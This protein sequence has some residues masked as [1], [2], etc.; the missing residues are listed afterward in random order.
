M[1]RPEGEDP[2]AWLHYGNRRVDTADT[3]GAL[4]A[5]RKARA[6]AREL[7]DG[8]C[9]LAALSNAGAQLCGAGRTREARPILEEAVALAEQIGGQERE[10]RR[11]LR[12]LSW[13][14]EL[15]D[16][17]EA[18]DRANAR[19]RASY[20][21]DLQSARDRAVDVGHEAV[22]AHVRGEVE[23]AEEL[24]LVSIDLSRASSTRRNLGHMLENLGNLRSSNGRMSG[25]KELYLEALRIHRQEKNVVGI[26][27][28][29]GLLANVLF[30][31]EDYSGAAQLMR[32]AADL[33]GQLGNQ[34]SEGLM[35]V[36]LGWVALE[37]RELD[38]AHRTI[39]RGLA[40]AREIENRAM[41]GDALDA[42]GLCA[43]E[44]GDYARAAGYHAEAEAALREGKR[45]ERVPVS[46]L[47]GGIARALSGDIDDAEAELARA[48]AAAKSR[49]DPTVTADAI[50]WRALVTWRRD[51]AEAARALMRAAEPW[52][53]RAES[54]RLTKVLLAIHD[55]I[56]GEPV[57]LETMVGRAI[58]AFVR[59]TLG[60]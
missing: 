19:L 59:D 40:M 28:A 51:G 31:E 17:D 10:Y 27:S 21:E 32:A 37:R 14:C 55:A 3:E 11:S 15:D 13:A 47:H 60:A 41:E 52:E 36:N 38:V 35:R 39:N 25:V 4:E 58:R 24:Y 29:S 1:S 42:L 45:A 44:S 23:Q 16:D 26:A 12:N 53:A 34:A 56:D 30:Q 22:R 48:E 7:G 49:D 46:I 5:Y 2:W 50:A 43:R 18:A 33:Y 9:E 54:E 57:E 8:A 20:G 6:F